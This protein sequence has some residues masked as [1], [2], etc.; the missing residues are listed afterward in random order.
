MSLL[1]FGFTAICTL[2]IALIILARH[3]RLV[4]IAGDSPANDNAFCARPTQ[5]LWPLS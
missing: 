4:Y 5:K 3:W 2:P 1:P